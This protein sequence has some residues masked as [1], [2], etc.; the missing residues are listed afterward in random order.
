MKG[1][2]NKFHVY[3]EKFNSYFKMHYS[4]FLHIVDFLSSGEGR[5][6]GRKRFRIGQLIAGTGSQIALSGNFRKLDRSP[7]TLDNLDCL[8]ML[9]TV[10][11]AFQS[12][13]QLELLPSPSFKNLL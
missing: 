8:G 4:I 2:L 5:R 6:S 3:K 7:S 1:K 11:V 9:E 10:F 12:P 13:F